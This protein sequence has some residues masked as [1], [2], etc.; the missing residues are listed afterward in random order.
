VGD[1]QLHVPTVGWR[2]VRRRANAAHQR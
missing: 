1:R 2:A